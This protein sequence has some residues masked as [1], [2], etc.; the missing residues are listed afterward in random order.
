MRLC[1]KLHNRIPALLPTALE[2]PMFLLKLIKKLYPESLRTRIMVFTF[3]LICTI[4]ITIAYLVDKQGKD[5]L[6]EEKEQKLFLIAHMLDVELGNVF[7]E[8]FDSTLSPEEQIALFNKKLSPRIE[9]LLADTP[10]IGAGYYNKKLDCIVLYAP[11][12]LHG[13]TIGHQISSEHPG[14][15]V[16]QTGEPL[17]WMGKQVRGNIMN[18][19]IPI[20]REGEIQG[21]IW[22][23]ELADDIQAQTIALD[24]NIFLVCFIG[25]I[26]SILLTVWLSNRLNIDIE[27]I[28]KALH[29]LPFNKDTKLPTLK[30][31]MN[32]I[33]QGVNHL[34]S[35]LNEAKTLNELILESMI[36]GVIT[37]DNQGM[38]T[39]FNPAAQKITGY[40]L[41]K[42]IGKPYSNIFDDQN[43]DSPLLDT[44]ANGVDHI[45]IET[46]FPVAGKI[47][48][49]SSSTSHLKNHQGEI[50]GALVIFKDLTSQKKMQRVI[51]QTER[52]LA[53]GELMAG[54]AHEIRN[55]LTAVRGFVQYLK[56]EKIS[57]QEKT[58]YINIILQ[59]VDSINQVIEQLQELS[60][61]PKSYFSSASLNQLT[62][63]TLLLVKTT[64]LQPQIDFVVQLDPHL[65][66]IYMDTN[67][68]KQVLLNLLINAT[69]AIE[70][71]GTV[72]IR[73]YLT[74]N[75]LMQV[76]EI[77]DTGSGLAEE[78]S[79]H[80]FT[81][82]FTTKSSGTGLG[83]PIVQ[84]IVTSH[85]GTI[86]IYN[87]KEGGVVARV[88]LPTF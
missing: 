9:Q 52:L 86:Q 56:K 17:L 67:Q 20:I 18:A 72:T 53:L 39:M 38:V 44:L 43:F 32:E 73:S 36:D 54:V 24:K 88:S 21:Y 35:S 74:D 13:N 31:E 59:G 66:P 70:G 33:A 46:D 83:L 50:I 77:R 84:K 79:S 45:G 80:I 82:F 22:A 65:E 15:I 71:K 1:G 42:A 4:T 29:T 7:S 57:Q 23:N 49:L 63:E 3:F 26:C 14:R 58:E 34:S 76:V 55:P 2:T 68:I 11:H 30:G 87:H 16:M 28:K 81:P 61:P 85:N 60:K 48:Q 5:F 40:P 6:I 51:Q 41:E 69:Q 64:L 37:V 25:L 78:I 47:L 27:I 19:M 8:I 10:K 62:E 12:N 75:E